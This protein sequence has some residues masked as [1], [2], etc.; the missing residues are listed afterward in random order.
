MYLGENEILECYIGDT[1]ITEAYLGEELVFSSG[2]FVGLKMPKNINFTPTKL[3]NTIKVKASES[4]SFTTI[5]TG[6][7][8]SPTTG[9]SGVT[10]VTVTTSAY[11]ASTT[12]TLVA[13]S[14]NY[15]ASATCNYNYGIPMLTI[16]GSANIV[17]D[18]YPAVAYDN[19]GG[20]LKWDLCALWTG[21]NVYAGDQYLYQ[22]DLYLGNRFFSVERYSSYGTYMNVGTHRV[23]NGPTNGGGLDHTWV[24][25]A[26][27]GIV[28]TYIDGA[29]T[30]TDSIE[31]S[32]SY[33]VLKFTGGSGR[34]FKG[35]F[36]WL[37]FYDQ[38][39]NLIK[40]FRPDPSGGI[41]DIVTSTVYAKTGTGTTEYSLYIP[42]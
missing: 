38:N 22:C 2:P 29:Q 9:D 8:V 31:G 13:T 27:S 18:F 12:E 6:F 42:E 35:N 17:T 20:Y 25:V 14:A 5:P 33:N 41:I 24:V 28:T 23:S 1:A 15:I 36:Y 37:K 19:N 26:N 3:E 34:N 11:T 16:N 10:L 32:F 21:T 39:D 30:E 4:W 40:D 7:T